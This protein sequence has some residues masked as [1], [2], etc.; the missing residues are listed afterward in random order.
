MT[1]PGIII[2]SIAGLAVGCVVAIEILSSK[3]FPAPELPSHPARIIMAEIVDDHTPLAYQQIQYEVAFDPKRLS[4]DKSSYNF[5]PVGD[6]VHAPGFEC[7]A[8]GWKKLVRQWPRDF[9]FYL[10]EELP[11]C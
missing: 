11:P 10:I 9:G 1:D 2:L 4:P 7:R 6:T 8:Q 5:G 3:T